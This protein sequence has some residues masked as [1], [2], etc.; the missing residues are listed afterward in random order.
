MAR[1]GRSRGSGSVRLSWNAR[2]TTTGVVRRGADQRGQSPLRRGGPS[3]IRTQHISARPSLGRLGIGRLPPCRPPEHRLVLGCRNLR[4]RPSRRGLRSVSPRSGDG[5]RHRERSRSVGPERSRR[6]NDGPQQ[7]DRSTR[8]PVPATGLS[9]VCNQR[10]HLP[11]VARMGT[12]SGSQAAPRVR[13]R[14][15]EPSGSEVRFHGGLP[16]VLLDQRQ[17][18]GTRLPPLRHGLGFSPGGHHATRRRLAWRRGPQRPDLPR[19]APGGSHSGGSDPR[20]PW[21]G[22]FAGR[23]SPGGDP[24]YRERPRLVG[25]GS[26]VDRRCREFATPRAGRALRRRRG[27]RGAGI[28]SIPCDG[29]LSV[30][31]SSARPRG[32]SA[33][34]CRRPRPATGPGRSAPW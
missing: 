25:P 30:R 8:S 17:G 31:P 12:T 27:R 5:C 3:G 34:E 13:S 33:P 15:A 20:V 24:A 32:R 2:V 6:R 21:G 9:T 14:G 23:G 29:I 18:S 16:T 10:I 22:S 11:A 19:T 26:T 4:R 1:S 28:A 7:G